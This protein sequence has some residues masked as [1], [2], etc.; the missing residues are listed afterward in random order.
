MEQNNE[1]RSNCAAFI[2]KS[3]LHKWEENIQVLDSCILLL[4][5]EGECTLTVDSAKWKLAKGSVIMLLP[6]ETVRVEE[7]T[8]DI[9]ADLLICNQA[10]TKE[11]FSNADSA[12]YETMKNNRSFTHIPGIGNDLDK[13][14]S[15]LWDFQ[16][17]NKKEAFENTAKLQLKSL[18][19]SIEELSRAT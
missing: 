11:S 12:I 1:Q 18:Y 17:E 16:N 5:H 6:E 14:F 4:C 9:E 19:S 10:I 3:D 7:S 8:R 15:V 2:T 13:L